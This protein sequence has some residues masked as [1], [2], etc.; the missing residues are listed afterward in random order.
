MRNKTT[1]TATDYPDPVKIFEGTI[2]V[3]APHMDDEMLACGAT[4]AA[5]PE[6]H[7][8]HIIYA[9][10]GTRSPVPDRL[11]KVRTLAKLQAVRTTE[12]E[13]ALDTLGIPRGN[14]T[15]LGL[16]DGNLDSSEKELCDILV[17]HLRRLRPDHVFAPFQFDRHPDHLAVYR[18]TVTAL[19]TANSTASLNEYFV[20][21]RWRLL[22]GGDVRNMIRN[23]LLIRIPVTAHASEKRRAL[24]CYASQTTKYFGWQLRPILT[25]HSIEEVCT[26]PECF[27]QTDP[28]SRDDRVFTRLVP[29]IKCA[30]LLEPRLKRIKDRAISV[31]HRLTG[32]F[33]Q[34]GGQG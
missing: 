10:D 19:R 2:L 1:D 26:S 34:A 31:R 25:S 22:P 16:P 8:I 23:D 24:A 9:T 12:A 14:A 18:A 28:D 27:L 7:A 30:H 4:L 33:S 11:W 17:T 5:L 6:K 32:R 29:W 13:N 3:I 20:Y 21:F 15:F